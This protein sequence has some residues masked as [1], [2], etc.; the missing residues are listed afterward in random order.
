MFSSWQL[1][2]NLL[3]DIKKSHQVSRKFS[4]MPHFCYSPDRLRQGSDRRLPAFS[5]TFKI[6]LSGAGLGTSHKTSLEKYKHNGQG[7]HQFM[8]RVFKTSRATVQP[9]WQHCIH[10]ERKHGRK[11]QI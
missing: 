10:A 9:F 3:Q 5:S 7:F 11:R 1:S 6:T 8:T 4:I 2:R